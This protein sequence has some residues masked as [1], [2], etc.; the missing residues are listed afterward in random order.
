[1]HL[2]FINLITDCFPALALGMERAEPDTMKR[3]PRNSREGIF[4]G[5]LG[6]DIT[7]Q[8][9]LITVITIVSYIL[10][11]CFEAGA[12]SMPKGVSSHGM[13]MAF[14]TMSMCEI[15]H[16]FNMRSQRKSVFS[17]H[18][19][20]NILWLAMVGSLI[21]TTLVL[22]IPALANAFGFTPVGIVEYLVAIV[23]AVIVIPVVEGIKFVQRK[24]AKN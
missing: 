22:E 8:G 11:H 20:N 3:P 15:F 2:L 6:V 10:G 12:F 17:L 14:L 21:L 23:L 16:S 5:G 4:A 9:V 19:H 13:T 18:S 1:V 7:Y 24:L